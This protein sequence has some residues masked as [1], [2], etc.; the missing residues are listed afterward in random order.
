MSSCP[1]P[2]IRAGRQWRR[3]IPVA[4]LAITLAVTVRA[5][6]LLADRAQWRERPFAGNTRYQWLTEAGFPVLRAE[7][8]GQASAL[9]REWPVDLGQT[10]WL[11]WQWRVDQVYP[12]L[13]PLAKAGDDYPA[14]LYVVVKT[15]PFPWQTLALNY[16]WANRE[17][18]AAFWPNPF[19][20]RAVMMPLRWGEAGAGDWQTERVNVR[21]DLQRAFGR[22]IDRIDGVAVMT[23][24]DNSDSDG[25]AWYRQLR[26]SAGVDT[27]GGPFPLH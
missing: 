1:E 17:P 8:R 6:D 10:P 19:T 11:Q 12:G 18:P 13:D 21:A 16:V 26:F 24:G 2:R 22:D 23:D 4:L 15:G 3:S 9:Y 27:P 25:V 5:E 7:T 20:D 14:R